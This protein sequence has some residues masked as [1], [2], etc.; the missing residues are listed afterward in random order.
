MQPF[1]VRTALAGILAL[2]SASAVGAPCAGFSDVQDT[3]A[4]CREVQWLK[5]RSITFGCTANT[6]CPSSAVTRTSMALFLNRLGTALTP[7]LEFMEATLGAVDPDASPS[8]CPTV[9][10]ASTVY[11]RQALVW[12]A[13]AGQAAGDLG[14]AARP[15]V[16]VDN[17]ATW[18]PVTNPANDIRESVVGAAW[19]NTATSGIYPIPA[20]QSVRFGV[21]VVRHSGGADFTQGRCHVTANIMN[22]NGTSSPFDTQ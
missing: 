18:N 21:G 5:N 22:A 10:I 20:T 17:G 7:R 4:F 15:M 3:D 8:L 11:P 14:Y 1:L 12:V 16:S 13:F 2:G 19:T 6:Y 9:Q